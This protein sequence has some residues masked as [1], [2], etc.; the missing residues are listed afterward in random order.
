MLNNGKK[1]VIN[2]EIILVFLYLLPKFDSSSLFEN[3][4]I[5]FILDI[6]I[7][8]IDPININNTIKTEQ[9]QYH[10]LTKEQRCKIEALVNI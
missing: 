10:H 2:V 6:L 8:F 4:L 1:N 3:S 9:N 7:Q 5:K